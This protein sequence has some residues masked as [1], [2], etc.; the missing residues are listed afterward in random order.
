MLTPLL[1]SEIF[2]RSIFAD[3][4]IASVQQGYKQFIGNTY[5]EAKQLATFDHLKP[6]KEKTD[7][8][9]SSAVMAYP[10]NTKADYVDNM[11]KAFINFLEALGIESLYMLEFNQSSLIDFPFENFIKRNAFKRMAR[12]K[13]KDIG[14]EL[15]IESL[16]KVLP[17]FYFSKRYDT[18]VLTLLSANDEIPIAFD[19]CD[20]GNWHISY[21]I[22][23]EATVCNTAEKAGFIIGD[24]QLCSQYY[25][26]SLL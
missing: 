1:R 20:D 2:Q 18:A 15:E 16:K 24:L 23:V 14:F 11:A 5:W 19:L 8:K 6:F 12:T 21:P 10:A 26:H 13:E 17:L 3:N 25:V 4:Y 7:Y 22:M 9:L